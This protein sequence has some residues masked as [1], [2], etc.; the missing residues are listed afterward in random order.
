MVE[1]D[2]AR[3]EG[4][5]QILRSALTLS[6]ITGRP[7]RLRNVRAR[8]D[9]T[10]LRPQ[11]LAC[12]R[13]AEAIGEGRAEGAHVGSSELV[14]TP[15]TVRPADHL[16]DVGT[17]GSAPLLLQCLFYPLAVAGGG[18]LTLR[19]GTHLPH[20]PAYPYL[21]WIW[22]PAVQ[23]FGFRA[24]L[25]LMRAGFYPEGGGE[26]RA[27]IGPLAAPPERVEL[28]TRGTLHEVVVT[29][30]SA[31][32]PTDTSERQARA[33]SSALRERG[34]VAQVERVPLPASRSAG[35]T[36]FI[37][38]Q[39]EHTAAGFTG[40]TERRGAPE[41]AGREAAGAF[42]RFMQSTGALDEHLSDQILLPA[43]LLA[44]GKLGAVTP[45]TT[46]FRPERVSDH[47][48]THAEVVQAF[49]E[50]KVEIE[51]DGAVLVRPA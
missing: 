51:G 5:G 24:S 46:R 10:G 20:S 13:G 31:N 45:G 50:V 23:A 47:L 44:A 16:L 2:G 37:R 39:F 28:P 3:G 17:A 9:P 11:H 29:S 33:A 14:F 42:A 40:L 32:L 19:G 43:A 49:L 36:V 35:G 34:I 38:A 21:S 1:L 30:W 12:V 7:F 22:L 27:E 48:T 6:L 25:Q 4:G 41:N 8:R 15:G 18:V 26:L